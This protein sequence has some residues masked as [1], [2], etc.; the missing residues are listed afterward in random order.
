MK[1]FDILIVGGGAAG[2]AAAIGAYEAGCRSIAIVDR[3]KTLGGVLLQCLHRGFGVNQDGPEYTERLLREFPETVTFFSSTTVLSITN[4]RFAHLSGGTDIRFQALVLATGCREI[5]MGALPIAGT[6][7]LGIYTAGQM[8]E[9]MNLHGCIPEGPAVILGSGD[10]GLVMANHLAQAGIPVTLVEKKDTCGG[11]VRNQRCLEE[12]SVRLICN[13]TVTEVWGEKRLESCI[14]STG[15]KLSCKTLL[16]AVG[17]VPDRELTADLGN[18]RWLHICGN[19][20]RVHPMVEAVVKE[21]KL[22]GIA[23]WNEIRGNL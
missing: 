22:A 1:E 2:I 9:R 20:N 6:R 17:L 4:E 3:Q 10:L 18:P 15:E 8:Q 19:C 5:P 13:A 11:M 14:L 12:K 7:P 23:A 21:G 16:I